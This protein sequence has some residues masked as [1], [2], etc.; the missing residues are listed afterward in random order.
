M[1]KRKTGMVDIVHVVEENGDV[2]TLTLKE[3]EAINVIIVT[4]ARGYLII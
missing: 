3:E 2:L 1:L 4:T